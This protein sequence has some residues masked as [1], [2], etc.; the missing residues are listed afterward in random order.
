MTARLLALCATLFVIPGVAAAQ[1]PATPAQLSQGESV[2]GARCKMCHEPAVERAP[3]AP[4]S[5][6]ASPPRW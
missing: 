5:L 6:L 2:F 3:D 1:A 4:N